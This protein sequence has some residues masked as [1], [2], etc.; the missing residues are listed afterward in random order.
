MIDHVI[1]SK[2][3]RV[4]HLTLTRQWFDE[5]ASGRKRT[6][7]RKANAYWAA[8]LLVDGEMFRVFDEIHF[9]N[10]YAKA[11]PWMRVTWKGCRY[12]A[13]SGHKEAPGPVYAIALGRVLEIKNWKPKA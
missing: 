1:D 7:Y 8:R 9:R 6:E 13:G 2:V 4:L 12:M 3:T 11:A 10:G 5:I